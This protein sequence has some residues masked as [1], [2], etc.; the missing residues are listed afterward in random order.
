[1]QKSSHLYDMAHGTPDLRRTPS[2][3]SNK[4]DGHANARVS[5]SPS[6]RSDRDFRGGV[7]GGFFRVLVERLLKK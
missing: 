7:G 4:V 2:P 3:Q 1:M 5:P 6:K